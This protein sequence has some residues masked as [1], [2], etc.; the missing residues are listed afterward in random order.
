[1]LKRLPDPPAAFDDKTGSMTFDLRQHLSGSIKSE[2]VIFGPTGRLVSR[3]VADMEGEWDGNR[4]QLREAFRFASGATE[5]RCWSIT[6]RDDGRYTATAGDIIGQAGGVIE[7][8]SVKSLYRLKLG[9]D[10]GNHIVSVEDWMYLSES[11]VI[12]NRSKFRKF[13]IK[14]GELFATL[15]PVS[16]TPSSDL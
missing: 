2:G 7:G 15:R 13:G 4:G 12:L 6:L 5:Q 8:T 9:A 10:A 16:G 1:M 14:V 11:G 3:F